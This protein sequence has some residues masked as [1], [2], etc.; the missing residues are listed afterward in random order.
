MLSRILWLSGLEHGHNRGEGVD[1]RRRFIYIH[2]T[3]AED[4]LGQPASRGCIRLSNADVIEL[5]GLVSPGCRVL[6]R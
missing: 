1:S 4:Q 2:G 5:C 6:V 3:N